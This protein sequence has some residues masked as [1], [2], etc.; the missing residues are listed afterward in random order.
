M[1]VETWH[2]SSVPEGETRT[3]LEENRSILS[4]AASGSFVSFQRNFRTA[5]RTGWKRRSKH[6]W[7]PIFARRIFPGFLRRGCSKKKSAMDFPVVNVH[8]VSR[9]RE[10]RSS[11]PR[12]SRGNANSQCA[13]HGISTYGVLY[14]LNSPSNIPL[15]RCYI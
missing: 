11:L 9:D 15:V 5:R 7:N 12:E 1:R 14:F 10:N 4:L 6:R 3:R 8:Q 13:I 2:E